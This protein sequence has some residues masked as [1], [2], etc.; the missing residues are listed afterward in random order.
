[1]LFSLLVRVFLGDV[2]I[3]KDLYENI[4]L[5]AGITVLTDVTSAATYNYSN[6]HAF[7]SVATTS[8]NLGFYLFLLTARLTLAGLHNQLDLL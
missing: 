1:M 6:V 5:S 4:V 7:S 8:S 3:R 2:A